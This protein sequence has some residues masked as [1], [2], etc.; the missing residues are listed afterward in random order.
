MSMQHHVHDFGQVDDTH[1]AH[2]YRNSVGL[3]YPSLYEGFGIPPLEAMSCGTAVI[4]SSA[5][6]LPEV[7]G[8][9]AMVFDPYDIEYLAALMMLLLDSPTTRRQ[10]IERGYRQ[11]G[12][13][14][15][16]QTARHTH[17]VYQS[18]AGRTS[19]DAA[20]SEPVLRAA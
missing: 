8:D 18:V 2:L 17:C 15:W 5:A 1:L 13:F 20:P 9:A 7:V 3:V 14:S 10:L 4:C 19:H 6:S 16:A 12:R 11:A